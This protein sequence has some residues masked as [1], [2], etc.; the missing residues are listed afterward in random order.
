MTGDLLRYDRMVEGAM[1]GVMA[2]ALR[3]VAAGGLPGDHHFYI[4]FRTAY[5][6]V[7]IGAE[8]KA[9]HPAEMTI[10]LQHQFWDLEVG[11]DGFSVMLSFGGVP[12]RLTVPF[13]AVTAFAD[14]SVKF[15]LQFQAAETPET[16]P[17]AGE[18]VAL[19]KFRKS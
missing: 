6:G 17:P 14:P 12:Q 5:P 11:R 13:A 10:I 3:R 9:R 19:D 15:G 1:R 4:V 2:E 18:V 16:A 7:G 8:L